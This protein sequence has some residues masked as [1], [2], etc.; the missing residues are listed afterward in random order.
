MPSTRELIARLIIAALCAG[1]VGIERERKTWAAGMRTHMLVGLG[2]ALFMLVSSF[3]FSEALKAE[4]VVLDPS[5]VAAQVVSGIGFLGA[6][7]ILF[8]RKGVVRGLT[9]ASGMWTVSGIGLAIGGGMYLAGIA[10]TFIAIAIL[11]FLKPVE[12]MLFPKKKESRILATL[13]TPGVSGDLMTQ[14]MSLKNPD[15]LTVF[16]EK[17]END[18]WMLTIKSR[19]PKQLG[20]VA[21]ILRRSDTVPEFIVDSHGPGS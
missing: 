20:Q 18:K 7:T 16:F 6:G 5:R 17:N 19:N 4:H 2:S 3:G 21:D 8:L 1:L 13:K 9:T 11:W 12:A 15:N 14:L 10:A